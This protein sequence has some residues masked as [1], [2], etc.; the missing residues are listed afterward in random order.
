MR[1]KLCNA[2]TGVP[3]AGLRQVEGVVVEVFPSCGLAHVRTAS[4]AIYGLNCGTP[5]ITFEE[6]REGQVLQCG[7][8]EKFHRVHSAS[9]VAE[10]SHEDL[11]QDATVGEGFAV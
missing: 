8:T 3:A 5:G 9:L 4:G 2:M 11:A 1:D 10:E 7:V 6:L